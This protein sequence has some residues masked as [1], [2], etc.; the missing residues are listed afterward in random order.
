MLV[1]LLLVVVQSLL[2]LFLLVVVQ[3]AQVVVVQVAQVAVVQVAQVAA[4]EGLD[5]HTLVV[6]LATTP[7]LRK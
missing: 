3:V 5:Y 6:I 2:G 4:L 1:L 7:F